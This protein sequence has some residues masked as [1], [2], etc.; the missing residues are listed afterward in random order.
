MA[1]EELSVSDR[2]LCLSGSSGTGASAR[3]GAAAAAGAA[4]GAGQACCSVSAGGTGYT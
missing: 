2:M 4:A 3:A 1:G